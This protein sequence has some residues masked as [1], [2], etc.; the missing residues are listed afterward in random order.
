MSRQDCIRFNSLG[1]MLAQAQAPSVMEYR[2]SRK[3][4]RQEWDDNTDFPSAIV[5]ATNGDIEGA[6]RLSPAILKELQASFGHTPR[7]DVAY[8]LEGGLWVDIDRF[9]SGEPELWGNMIQGDPMPSRSLSIVYNASYS[10]R[11]TA[12]QIDKITVEL[13]S[14]ILGAQAM[15]YSVSLY[16][17]A[18]SIGDRGATSITS[19]PVNPNATALDVSILSAILRPWFF[20]RIIFSIWETQGEAFR[21]RF[22]IGGGYGKPA[23]L[24][25]E[26]AQAIT[27]EA[28]TLVIN[29]GDYIGN[30]SAIKDEINRHLSAKGA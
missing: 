7:F 16:I 23:R 3:E 6:K 8:D 17:C 22:H 14:A 25:Q 29:G 1:D 12:S 26:E 2:S 11:V 21:K 20:R 13:G 5:K 15:G 28:K 18:K 9:N 30:P 10:Y 27:S 19:A 24:A 4:A